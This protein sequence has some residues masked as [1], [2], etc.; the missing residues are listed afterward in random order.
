MYPLDVT[1]PLVVA[2]FHTPQLHYTNPYREQLGIIKIKTAAICTNYSMDIGCRY[3]Y[4]NFTYIPY[5]STYKH[6]AK[7]ISRGLLRAY[8]VCLRIEYR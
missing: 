5:V 7:P 3:V 6:A 2:Q 1:S 4:I 8:P